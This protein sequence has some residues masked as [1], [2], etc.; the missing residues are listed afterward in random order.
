MKKSIGTCVYAIKLGLQEILHPSLLKA[1][2][3]LKM[4]KIFEMMMCHSNL[5][6]TGIAARMGCII[7]L[8]TKV[9]H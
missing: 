3:P 5:K 9:I 2:V 4:L 8:V 1:G 6:P 7:G